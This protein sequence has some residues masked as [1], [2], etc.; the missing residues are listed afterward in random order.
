[1]RRALDDARRKSEQG[2]QERQ[3]EVLEIDV[4]AELAR[5]FPHDL[6]AYDAKPLGAMNRVDF[7][8]LIFGMSS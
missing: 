4:E 6:V 3:G 5:C 7:R 1:M 8:E 2:S